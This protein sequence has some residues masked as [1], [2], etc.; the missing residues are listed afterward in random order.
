MSVKQEDIFD[1]EM[2][3]TEMWKAIRHEQQERNRNRLTFSTEMLRRL[4]VPFESKN[5]GQHL[6]VT[7]GGKIVD[8]WPSTGRWRFRTGK[9][10]RSLHRLLVNLGINS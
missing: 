5:D 2:T 4:Q 6:I 1:E 7:H 10:G 9:H 8:F 3:D